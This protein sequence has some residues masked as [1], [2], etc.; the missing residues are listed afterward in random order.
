MGHRRHHYEVAFEGFL[1]DRRIP[2]VSVNEARKAL[3]PERAALTVA[4]GEKTDNLK[5]FDFVIYG[6]GAN[7]LVEVKGRKIGR[8]SGAPG[9][10]MP[11]RSQLQSWITR[12]DVDSLGKWE[13]LFG[14]G[15]EAV[16]LF[17][18]WC[19]D[20]PPDGLFQE[21]F[22][23]RD[24]WYALRAV[25]LADYREHMKTRS[26]RWKTVF[27]PTDQFERISQP[28]APPPGPRPDPGPGVPLVD[29]IGA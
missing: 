18:Y 22:V 28:F 17:V 10:R 7:L 4:D 13:T 8:P 21:V 2:Y 26:E 20:S 29:P 11:T 12:D 23:H 6:D 24:R 16:I 9:T 14:D 1:R 19:D 25:R 3:L 5:S 15:F 27:V